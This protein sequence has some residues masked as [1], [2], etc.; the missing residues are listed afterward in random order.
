MAYLVHE[1]RGALHWREIPRADAEVLAALGAPSE[2]SLGIESTKGD[3][4]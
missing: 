1:D 4:R 3:R 2:I